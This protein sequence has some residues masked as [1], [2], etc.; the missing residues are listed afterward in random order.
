MYVNVNL[1][2]LELS[3]LGTEKFTSYIINK[4]FWSLNDNREIN[5]IDLIQLGVFQ[6]ATY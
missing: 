2:S 3:L 6:Q 5:I 4:Y 1:I